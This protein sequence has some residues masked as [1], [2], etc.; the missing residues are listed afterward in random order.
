MAINELA[1]LYMLPNVR[2]WIYDAHVRLVCTTVY[3]RAIVH[4]EEC[5]TSIVLIT[6]NTTYYTVEKS[7]ELGNAGMLSRSSQMAG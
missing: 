2:L 4:L 6:F 7:H 5:I 3:K 1:C